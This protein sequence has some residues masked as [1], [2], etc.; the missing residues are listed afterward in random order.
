MAQSRIWCQIAGAWGL[1]WASVSPSVSRFLQLQNGTIWFSISNGFL[2]LD[3]NDMIEIGLKL[4]I[5]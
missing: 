1:G 3:E 4:G 5:W 2:F